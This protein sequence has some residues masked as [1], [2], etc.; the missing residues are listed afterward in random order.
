MGCL[1][2][3]PGGVPTP[4]NLDGLTPAELKA[5]LLELLGRVRDLERQLAAR[6][7]E[8][9]RLK[10]L[11]G[12]P[13]IRPSGMEPA[14]K[15]PDGPSCGRRRGGGNK[16][17]RRTIHEDRVIKAAVPAGSRF[18]GYQSFVVQD[19]VL[20]AHVLR[21]RRERWLTPEGQHMTAPL[22]V[23]MVGHFGPELRCFVLAQ[24]HQGQV[25]VARLMAQLR[26]IGI[27]ISQRQVMRLLIGGQDGFVTEARDV[28]RAGL[29]TASWISVD[30]TGARHA[31]ANGVC[32][33]I[34]NQ[35]FAWFGS[36]TNKSRLNFLGLAKTCAKLG[37][38]FWDYLGHRLS[39]AGAATV[40]ALPDLVRLRAT[41]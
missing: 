36:S 29:E 8:I 37:V 39:V 26:A 41:A 33:Q 24:Y 30:D 28:L 15:A 2:R 22:P 23:G 1:F 13:D 27:D 25:T 18:K 31:G 10:G 38:S 14:A 11:K 40:P 16:T 9:A 6:D 5:L 7:A 17:A 20:R 34:G 32:T 4:E 19:L 12:R 21:L 3:F 35:D